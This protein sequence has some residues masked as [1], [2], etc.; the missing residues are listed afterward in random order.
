MDNSQKNDS[1]KIITKDIEILTKRRNGNVISHR[2]IE[3]QWMVFGNYCKDI[4]LLGHL[5][6]YLVH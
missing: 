1:P 6:D 2:H 5:V 3:Q 4:N